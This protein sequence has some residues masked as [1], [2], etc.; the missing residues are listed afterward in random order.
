MLSDTLQYS[1]Q[2]IVISLTC[3]SEQH[4][5]LTFVQVLKVSGSAQEKDWAQ[6]IEP[7]G[8]CLPVVA[9]DFTFSRQCTTGASVSLC[10]RPSQL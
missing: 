1:Y 8:F 2:Q 9:P 10:L 6:R 7:V 4:A 3:H 5:L